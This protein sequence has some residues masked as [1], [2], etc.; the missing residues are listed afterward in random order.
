MTKSRNYTRDD[1]ND[2][3]SSIITKPLSG[4]TSKG[5]LDVGSL[6]RKKSLSPKNKKTSLS[7]KNKKTTQPKGKSGKSNSIQTVKKPSP[8]LLKVKGEKTKSKTNIK[9]KKSVVKNSNGMGIKSSA[10]IKTE[11]KEP[12][13]NTTTAQLSRVK[14]QEKNTIKRVNTQKKKVVKK[15]KIEEPKIATTSP[16]L[17]IKKNKA[18]DQ[19]DENSNSVNRKE[20]FENEIVKYGKNGFMCFSQD[21]C[22]GYPGRP[23]D[24]Y[25]QFNI[26]DLT[27]VRRKTNF[28]KI[29]N[30]KVNMED[31]KDELVKPKEVGNQSIKKKK[32][33]SLTKACNNKKKPVV[34]KQQ[35]SKKESPIYEVTKSGRKRTIKTLGS[36]F[37]SDVKQ[38]EEE[39]KHVERISELCAVDNQDTLKSFVDTD[40]NLPQLKKKLKKKVKEGKASDNEDHMHI[41]LVVK[42]PDKEKEATVLPEDSFAFVLNTV[43]ANDVHLQLVSEPIEGTSSNN[44]TVF[45]VDRQKIPSVTISNNRNG[46]AILC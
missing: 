11:N 7:T 31:G 37:V 8:K 32:V 39:M 10:V 21:G 17:S 26:D 20:W 24:D 28:F 30:P 45:E 12:A 13:T 27:I 6:L 38:Y 35:V 5:N 2:I 15:K 40:P 16:L 9:Q 19:K 34:K 36:D 1:H 25:A 41:Q 29:N 23:G 42:D 22:F 4:P 43:M 3:L 44:V 33:N 46:M 14:S 18:T